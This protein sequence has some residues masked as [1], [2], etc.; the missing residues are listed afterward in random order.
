V[1]S[2][3]VNTSPVASSPGV[4]ISG[5][6][7]AVGL[8]GNNLPPGSQVAH[9]AIYAFALSAADVSAHYLKAISP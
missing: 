5:G 8:D 2:A 4:N 1:D 6:S 9:V 7:I 3:L